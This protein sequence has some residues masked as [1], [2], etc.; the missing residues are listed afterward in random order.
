M[1]ILVLE[2]NVGAGE[3]AS[4]ELRAAGHQAF[5]CLEQGMESFPCRALFAGGR[6]PL[7]DETIDVALLVRAHP[8]PS[9][10]QRERGV[11][12]ALRAGV[13]LVVAGQTALD[14]YE[15]WAAE[16]VDGTDAVVEVCE[17]VGRH[18]SDGRGHD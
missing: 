9:P 17:R 11:S 10:T 3:K 13:P 5:T 12:C 18:E 15:R 1:N 7:D 6:C 16:Q 8:W 14:P 2:S 4:R